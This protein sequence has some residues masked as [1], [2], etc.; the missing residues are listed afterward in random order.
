MPA[1]PP[2][3]PSA[4]PPP[5][6]S[7]REIADWGC[8]CLLKKRKKEGCSCL[9]KK[10]KKEGGKGSPIG[11]PGKALSSLRGYPPPA[12]GGGGSGGGGGRGDT[13]PPPF[14]FSFFLPRGIL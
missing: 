12:S 14:F 2:Q 6:I 9:L 4:R 5:A 13:P 7:L 1:Q 3:P 11:P 8:S 10:R